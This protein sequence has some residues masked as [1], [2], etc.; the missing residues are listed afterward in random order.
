MHPP[1]GSAHEHERLNGGNRMCWL[2]LKNRGIK[3][4]ICRMISEIVTTCR[5]TQMSLFVLFVFVALRPKS[6]AMVIAG[7]SVHLTT[8]FSWAEILTC[9]IL[10]LQAH[11]FSWAGLN[12][13]L[14]SNS[15]TY[16]RLSLTSE[17]MCTNYWLTT[18]KRKYVHELLVNRLFKPA[19]ENKW[20]WR[21]KMV[22]VRISK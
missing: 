7:R 8:P 13:R 5:V 4:F 15:C 14:N 3:F 6:T 9:T 18:D 20:A 21:S 10:D 11:L 19:Q 22:H 17:S 1:S 12:K 16:F 2:L